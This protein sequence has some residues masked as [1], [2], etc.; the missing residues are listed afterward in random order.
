MVLAETESEHIA[1]NLDSFEANNTIYTVLTSKKG[2]VLS[3][4]EEKGIHFPTLTD[5]IQ[6]IMNLLRALEPFHDHHMLHLDVSPDNIFLLSPENHETFSVRLLLLDFNS[7]Y[8]MD[9]KEEFGNQYYFGKTTYMA[10]EVML[11]RRTELGPWTDLYSVAILW[12]EI[13]E[14]KKF[15]TTRSW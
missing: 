6:F 15:Q 7:A 5:T 9:G 3:E 1:Q 2:Q 12:Y 13:L 11:H 10:P 8:S 14:G 4:M